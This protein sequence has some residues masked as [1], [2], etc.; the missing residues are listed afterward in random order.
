[1]E[2]F[3]IQIQRMA[4]KFGTSVYLSKGEKQKVFSF[5]KE[6]DFETIEF[7]NVGINKLFEEFDKPA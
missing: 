4:D 2:N 6:I 3:R 5:N 7:L 1:M